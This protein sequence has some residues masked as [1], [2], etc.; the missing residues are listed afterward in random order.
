M[1]WIVEE[2]NRE[3]EIFIEREAVL[4]YIRNR[5]GHPAQ[6][7]GMSC[8]HIAKDLLEWSGARRVTVWEENTGGATLT[9]EE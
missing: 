2:L 7:E 9:R 4:Y 5:Y 6:F 3:M 8:E 1:A